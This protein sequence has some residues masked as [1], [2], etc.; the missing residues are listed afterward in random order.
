MPVEI[1]IEGDVQTVAMPEGHATVT[2]PFVDAHVTV[3]PYS[4][5][6]RENEAIAA[7]RSQEA[8]DR[9]KKQAK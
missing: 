7:W 1:R 6:L 2:L 8:A 3:D 9:Q 4:K 5:V